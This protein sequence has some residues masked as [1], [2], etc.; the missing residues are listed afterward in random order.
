ML[1]ERDPKRHARGSNCVVHDLDIPQRLQ[2]LSATSDVVGG[3]LL[4]AVDV[5]LQATGS[6]HFS[7]PTNGMVHDV[8]VGIAQDQQVGTFKHAW[9]LGGFK[10]ELIEKNI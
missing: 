8:R 9:L 10:P 4:A 1:D 5:E 7:S 2:V 6:P 3:P